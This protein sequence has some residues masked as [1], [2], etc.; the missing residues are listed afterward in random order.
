MEK[1][2]LDKII[3][4]AEDAAEACSAQ[5]VKIAETAYERSCESLNFKKS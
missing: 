4:L 3:S 1:H 2:E 5:A